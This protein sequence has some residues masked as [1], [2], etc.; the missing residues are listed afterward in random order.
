MPSV[1]RAAEV[2]PSER[3]DAF[4][5]VIC[6]SIVPYGHP[7]GIALAA[8]D[9]VRTAN[10]GALRVMNLIWARGAASRASQ[11]LRRSDPAL[12]KIDVSLSGRFAVDQSGRQAALDAGSFTFVDLSRTHR[13]AA[14]RCQLAAV[15]F[16]RA[17]LPLRD[18]DI[19]EL[20]GLTFD[21]TQPGVG[22]VTSVV[23]EMAGDLGA[24]EGPAGARL[25][26]AILD[27]IS[28][29]LAG[30]LDRG[31]ALPAESRRRTLILRIRKFI[32]DNLG[33]PE[34]EPGLVAA[35]HHI[36][37]RHLH[38]IFE[39]QGTTVARLIRSRRLERCR[40]DLLDP[41]R[42]AAPVGAV[43]ARWGFRDPAY[44]NRIFRAEFGSPPGEYRRRPD[45]P[46][47]A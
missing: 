10:V 20:T 24:Y 3:V 11:Q 29:T 32:E 28:A 31:D 43:A 18:K 35:R 42:S 44:F 16:P 5:D 13:V 30:R 39:D 17:L 6:D 38:K 47:P 12:C 15:M 9:E 2:T 33:D 22:L 21:Q 27:L 14:Q 41:T 34:L 46:A 19:N 8:G 26:G 1:W 36:S 25:G 45:A 7:A 40:H 37:R 23:R 4:V